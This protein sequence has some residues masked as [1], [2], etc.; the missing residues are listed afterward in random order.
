MASSTGYGCTRA[1]AYDER[2]GFDKGDRERHRRYV[3]DVLAFIGGEVSSFVDLGCGSG[4]FANVFFDC[5][6]AIRGVLVDASPDMIQLAQRRFEQR[7]VNI[8][9]RT[10]AM[11]DLAWRATETPDVV[12]C[13]MALHFLTHP[14]KWHLLGSLAA[15]LPPNGSLL[16]I[17]HCRPAD[18]VAADLLDY[19][20]CSELR[21]S[22][23]ISSALTLRLK[24]LPCTDC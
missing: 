18:P 8:I 12:L 3:A 23:G 17:D 9:Y 22:F 4:F 5:W 14:A 15:A 24:I 7:R 6:P 21:R 10:E 2:S 19:I 13:A 1:A 16:L 11:Q 20:A